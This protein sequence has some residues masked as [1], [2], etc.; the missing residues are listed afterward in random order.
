MTTI[1]TVRPILLRAFGLQLMSAPVFA[2]LAAFL[3][4]LYMRSRRAAMELSDDDFVSFRAALLDDQ[5]V[6]AGTNSRVEAV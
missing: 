3:A 5:S 6:T 1:P 2:G 4:F